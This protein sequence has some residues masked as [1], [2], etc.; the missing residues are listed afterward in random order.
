MIILAS[1]SPRRRELLKKTGLAFRVDAGPHEESMR[2]GLT[3]R[4]LAR[5]LSYEKAKAVAGKYKNS[6]IIAADT[7]IVCRKKILGKPHTADEA[8]RMLDALSGR[9][10]SVIT[11]FTVMD[12]ETNKTISRSVETVVSF[13]KLSTEDIESYIRTGE[14]LDKAGA[15]AVQGAGAA[16][17]RK[18]EG[19]Y[20]NI[21]GLPL[22]DLVRVLRKFGIRAPLRLSPAS[23]PLSRHERL[24][25]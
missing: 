4:A 3:P 6:L 16:L 9:S 20:F 15:Y 23:A 13:R 25:L 17:V 7:F 22:N 11:G 21:V 10:H 2:S 8:R 19:D 24:R 14:P 1:A 18:I 5:Y 12:T